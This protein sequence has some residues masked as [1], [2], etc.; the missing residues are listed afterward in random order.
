ML[1]YDS[2]VIKSEGNC[3]G[4]AGDHMND[5]KKKAKRICCYTYTNE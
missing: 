1:K 2:V 5:G 4:T 3:T